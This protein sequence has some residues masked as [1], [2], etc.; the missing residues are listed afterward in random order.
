MNS[1]IVKF[2]SKSSSKSTR[3]ESRVAF[4]GSHVETIRETQKESSS[5]S[6]GH[7]LETVSKSKKKALSAVISS[8]EN[9]FTPSTVSHTNSSLEPNKPITEFISFTQSDQLP[10]SPNDISSFTKRASKQTPL[11]NNSF[12]VIHQATTHSDSA[13]P[14][15]KQLPSSSFK[16]KVEDEEKE[17]DEEDDEDD[18]EDEYEDEEDKSTLDASG[19]IASCP[20]SSQ[21]TPDSSRHSAIYRPHK[22]DQEACP[23]ENQRVLPHGSNLP[24]RSVSLQALSLNHKLPEQTKGNS[25]N[26]ADCYCPEGALHTPLRQLKQWRCANK[27]SSP[28]PIEATL[29]DFEDN[30]IASSCLAERWPPAID[31]DICH[32]SMTEE[33]ECMSIKSYVIGL[34]PATSPMVSSLSRQRPL[35]PH[36]DSSSQLA[37]EHGLTIFASRSTPDNSTDLI[38]HF[39]ALKPSSD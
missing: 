10:Q 39:E 25:F 30:H 20:V 19:K 23:T 15:R 32:N 5:M 24:T 28:A 38:S 29:L 3:Q 33:R 31:Q 26:K 17:D 37:S 9:I 22:T 35:L 6:L 8:V 2:D 4:T 1:S 14:M 7:T 21:I 16:V 36:H 12:I 18:D 13:T 34:P 27:L 11:A